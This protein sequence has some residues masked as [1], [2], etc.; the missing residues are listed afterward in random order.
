[1]VNVFVTLT[2]CSTHIQIKKT[3][4]FII[5]LFRFSYFYY[6]LYRFPTFNTF[7][8][9]SLLFFPLFVFKFLDL[10]VKKT[11]YTNIRN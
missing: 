11:S 9:N 4:I 1:M 3:H 2:F 6:S 7:F 10:G 5:F 8:F